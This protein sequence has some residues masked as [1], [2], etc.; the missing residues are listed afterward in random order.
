MEKN[1]HVVKRLL[2]LH[3][4][5]WCIYHTIQYFVYIATADDDDDDYKSPVCPS[6]KSEIKDRQQ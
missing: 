5:I 4:A 2:L 3:L 6:G 1:L